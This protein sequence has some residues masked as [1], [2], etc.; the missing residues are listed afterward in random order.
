[1][2]KK[3]GPLAGLSVVELGSTVAGPC[4]ARLLADFGADVIKIEQAEGDAIRSFSHRKEGVSL[5][6]ASMQ[7]GKRIASINLRDPEGRALVRALCEKADI[8]VENFRPGT[9]EGWGMGY[10]DLA[11][12]NPGLVMVR[13]SRTGPMPRAAATA[14]FARRSVGCAK[15]PA[16]P[17]GRRP[18]S[19]PLWPII[20]PAFTVPSAP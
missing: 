12:V 7:R 15:S 4:C 13:I 19:P 2:T 3:T 14:S 17:T 5:Y 11:K 18:V 10:D 8:V 1:M 9:L 20:S 16:T 6:S